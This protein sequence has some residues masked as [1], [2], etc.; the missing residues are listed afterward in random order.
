MNGLGRRARHEDGEWRAAERLG[1]RLALEFPN[2][3]VR[4]SR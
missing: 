1:A 4:T 2:A 3:T